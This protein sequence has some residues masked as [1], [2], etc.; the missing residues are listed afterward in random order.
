MQLQSFAA[1][2]WRPGSGPGAALR[3]ATTG[4]VIAE[5][6]AAAPDAPAMLRY[7]REVGGPKLRRLTFHERAA[8]LKALARD[9]SEHKEDFYRISYATGATRGDSWIDID[10]GIGTL[11]VYASK[12]TRELPDGCVYVDGGVEALSKTGSFV[13]QHICVPLEGAAVHI[14]AFN[15]PV[16]GMLEKLAPALLAGVPAI[17]KP[18]T[19]T[20]YLAE[21]VFRR[22]I[23]SGI[24]PEG[25]VQ[26]ICGGVGDLLEHLTC[27]D[28]VSFTGS[29]ATARKL[30]EHPAVGANAVRFTA[31][32]DSLN[33]SILGPDAGGGAPEL[34]LFVREVVR[35]MTVKAGQKCTAIRRAIVPAALAGE[36]LEALRAALAGVV[37]G[38]PRLEQVR[39]G[40]VA[41]LDQRREVSEQLQRLRREAQVVYGDGGKLEPLGADAVRGAFMAP[42]LLLC[43]EPLGAQAVH[44]VEAFGPV[45]TLLAYDDLAGAIALARR[46]GGSLAG[47]VFTADD[48]VAAQLTLGLAPFHGRVLV[49]NRHCAAESTGHGSPLPHL[50]HGGPGRAGGGEELGGIRGV[51][52]YLQRTAVQGT[53]E[54]IT[55]VS[56]RWA[57]GARERDPGVHPF[58]KPFGALELGDTF[59]SGEREVTVQDIERFAE[60]SGDRF[61]AHMDEAQAARN[62]LFG[63]RVAHGYFL[64]AAAAGLFVDPPYGPVLANFGLDGLRFVKP[65]RPGDRIRV[66]LTCKEK[67][68]RLGAGYGEVRW[69]AAITNQNGEA[70]ANY[71]VLTM[72]SEQAVPDS[73]APGTR[74][75]GSTSP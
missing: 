56:R 72:V 51:L 30:R 24:L 53:P 38:D 34:A 69:D 14:N 32:T 4:E 22:I 66:R 10:G 67:S 54:L 41:S 70:V 33:S 43:R 17:V 2:S 60:L 44:S 42:T 50:V 11:F 39:M 18:A 55:A 8:L 68:L 61:Y 46:G 12:G 1:G 35:E 63:G 52:H 16:W 47:S 6:S 71:D 19:Q 20:C 9:L 26:L 58:R 45:C 74:A 57:R 65:V 64:V 27:Q 59:R 13:G 62:P 48:G 3:D 36:V 73:P 40:P 31:E 23:E 28:L 75:R 7:A 37:V 29:A 5:A 21:R 25:A 49:V 15:F